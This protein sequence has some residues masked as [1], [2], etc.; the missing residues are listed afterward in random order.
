MP[1]HTNVLIQTLNVRSDAL[2]VSLDWIGGGRVVA[3]SHFEPF[4]LLVHKGSGHL[5]REPLLV[6]LGVDLTEG[7]SLVDCGAGFVL[8]TTG[9]D[10]L[11]FGLRWLRDGRNGFGLT[12]TYSRTVMGKKFMYFFCKR[13]YTF[14][15]KK[16]T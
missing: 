12:E 1:A 13:F 2:A 4:S 11:M 9:D 6:R 8:H 3:V 16:S 14:P 15:Y 10:C 5:A 7:A